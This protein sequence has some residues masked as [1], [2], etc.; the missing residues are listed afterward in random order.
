MASCKAI[1]D[2]TSK[3]AV[4]YENLLDKGRET[5]T[6]QKK[7]S[8]LPRLSPA[9]YCRAGNTNS[10]QLGAAENQLLRELAGDD[11]QSKTRSSS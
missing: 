1:T 7:K 11:C 5:L 10:A 8:T 4:Y 6:L 3:A 2:P 9:R